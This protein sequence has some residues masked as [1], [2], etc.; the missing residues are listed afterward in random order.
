MLKARDAYNT[1]LAALVRPQCATYIDEQILSSCKEH[2]TDVCIYFKDLPVN[3]FAD[4]G[5][6]VVADYYRT[7]GYRV[8]VCDDSY[9]HICWERCYD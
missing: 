8:S 5:A 3:I 4:G 9:L 6:R 7:L 2:R 1:Y